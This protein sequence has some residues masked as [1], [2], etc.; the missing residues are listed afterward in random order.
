MDE[1][2]SASKKKILIIDDEP[3]LLMI[4]ERRLTSSGFQ[5]ISA[6]QGQEGIEKALK[7]KP[8]LILL[9]VMMS[10]MDGYQVL[11]ILKV[12]P[13]TS[14]IRIVMF[15]AGVDP[16][17]REKSMHLGADDYINKSLPFED[18]L[19]KIRMLLYES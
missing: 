14:N 1:S 8:D 16:K 19:Q 13:A 4:I 12:T 17:G 10:G 9:D 2:G 7:E 6:G 3:T 15:T 5:V 11:K 18:V